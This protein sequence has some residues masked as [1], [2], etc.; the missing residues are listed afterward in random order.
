MVAGFLT[1]L[2]KKFA[3][4][5]I[6]LLVLPGLLYTGLLLVAHTAGWAHALD[7]RWL[8]RAAERWTDGPR[9]RTEGF[10]VIAAVAAVL[11]GA[12]AGLAAQTLG[13]LLVRAWLAEDWQAWPRPL[14]D[15][16]HRR[17]Q[18]RRTAWRT[19]SAR[20]EAARLAWGRAV[21]LAE[22]GH[23]PAGPGP[24][25]AVTAAH[26]AM[27]D[28]ALEE[29]AR[30]TWQGDRIAAV[31][32]TLYRRYELDLAT[33]WPALWL[34]LP[35]NGLREITGSRDAF[36][37]AGVLAGWGVLCLVP[38]ALWWP[39]LPI[40]AVLWVTGV[41]R[42]REAVDTYAAFVTAAVEL[43]AADLARTLGLDVPGELDKPTGRDLTTHLRS[44]D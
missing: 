12:A 42:A 40:A 34:T 36:Q 41:R 3:E 13:G 16:A 28:I 35:E 30:P 5:W 24:A 15:A 19:A 8:V 37:R 27:R 10:L 7:I 32:T 25:D 26:R 9:P 17:T 2:G 4:R 29:P 43:H 31:G 11:A 22:A 23:A 38:G 39:G 44:H 1:E 33:I 14:R 21:A 20:Y 6:T 18:S